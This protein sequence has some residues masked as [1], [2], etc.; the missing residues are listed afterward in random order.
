MY[1][2]MQQY[3][4]HATYFL[5]R[6]YTIDPENVRPAFLEQKLSLFS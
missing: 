1:C 3:G 6:F 4:F 2:V 5:K